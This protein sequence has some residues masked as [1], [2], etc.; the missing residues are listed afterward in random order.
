[1]GL[2]HM[3]QQRSVDHPLTVVLDDDPTGTQSATDV[4]VLFEWD[5][6]GL[7]AALAVSPSVYVLT[8]TRPLPEPEALAVIPEIRDHAPAGAERLGR[9]IRFVLRGDSTL[10]GHVFAESALFMGPD[11]VLVFVPAFPEVG[12]RTLANVHYVEIDGVEV[13]AH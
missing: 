10:R 2:N 7:E 12:R 13:P 1:G 5:R 11:A 8:N 3:Q 6:E 4:P 9:A